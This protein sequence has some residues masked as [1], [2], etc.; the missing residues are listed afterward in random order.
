MRYISPVGIPRLPLEGIPVS[1]YCPRQE[2]VSTRL[3]QERLCFPQITYFTLSLKVKPCWLQPGGSFICKAWAPAG[4]GPCL[5][6]ACVCSL[7][8]GEPSFT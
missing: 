8:L 7:P 1:G 3:H 5:P 4:R 2:P 6:G